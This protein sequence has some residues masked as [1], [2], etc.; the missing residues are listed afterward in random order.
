MS[1]DFFDHDLPAGITALDDYELHSDSADLIRQ[2]L[3]EPMVFSDA[4]FDR[5]AGGI[6]IQP[7]SADTGLADDGNVDWL[8]LMSSGNGGDMMSLSYAPELLSP[9]LVQADP[10]IPSRGIR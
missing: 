5:D 6:S 7:V 1:F 3:K 4:E 10:L 2:V 8:A 9:S